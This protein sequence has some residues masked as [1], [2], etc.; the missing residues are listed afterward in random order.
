MARYNEAM[1]NLMKYNTSILPRKRSGFDRSHNHATTFDSAYLIPIMCQDI[2]PTDYVSLSVEALVKMATPYHPTMDTAYL[3]L[4]AF[5]APSRL[6]WSNFTK[7]FGEN[8]DA[9]YNDPGEYQMPNFDYAGLEYTDLMD[10][11]GLP[12]LPRDDNFVI[13]GVKVERFRMYQRVW[14]E[15][16]RASE[17]Q[18]SVPLNLGDQVTS[19]EKANVFTLRKVG[20]LHDYFTSALPYPQ[21][22][23]S[24]FL[25]L[26]GTVPVVTSE[27]PHGLSSYPVTFDTVIGRQKLFG[28]DFGDAGQASTISSVDIIE[29]LP[30]NDNESQ[31]AFDNLYADMSRAASTT[32][33]DLR[34]AVTTQQLLEL[35]ALG[36][37]RYTSLLKS[38]FGC[39]TADDVLQRTMCLGSTRQII[40]MRTVAQTSST[41][42]G[43]ALGDLG[44][45]SQTRISDRKLVDQAF[46]EPGV[47]MVLCC[48]RPLHTYSQGLDCFFTKLNRFDYFYPVLDGLGNQPIYTRELVAF[49]SD[50]LSVV[51]PDTVFGYKPAWEEY[52]VAHNRV[53]GKMRPDVPQSLA[54]WNYAD[55]YSSRPTLSSSFISEDPSLIDRTIIVENEPQFIG[56]FAFNFI[57]ER[58]IGVRG[59]PGLTRF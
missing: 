38:H 40:G 53:S 23:D 35:D 45:F 34:I 21:A 54:T 48:V 39:I 25:P 41:A 30:G 9:E 7:F 57:H 51:D 28:F 20:K 58:P 32:V 50:D 15:W 19:Q 59:L 42:D 26:A 11:M 33:N 56:D 37:L 16:F 4:F 46:T 3:D 12:Y 17:L 44:A 14:N 6:M 47:L 29:P 10:Y 43:Q 5:Y 8:E 22:G 2:L 55:Y 31:I 52:R 36:G 13:T 27:N 24:V 49:D 18:N 1:N